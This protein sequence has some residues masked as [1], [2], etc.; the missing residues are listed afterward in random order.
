[1]WEEA[2]SSFRGNGEGEI[3]AECVVII[4]GRGVAQ[5]PSLEHRDEEP[6]WGSRRPRIFRVNGVHVAKAF[7]VGAG[8]TVRFTVQW[9][10][11]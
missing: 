4:S 9:G 3:R 7:R 6:A 5:A 10:W 11:G 2:W 8:V 1:V